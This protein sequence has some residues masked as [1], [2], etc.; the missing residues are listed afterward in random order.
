MSA[1]D[2]RANFLFRDLQG[3]THLLNNAI[4]GNNKNEVTTLLLQ[5]LEFC[6]TKTQIVDWQGDN[7]VMIKFVFNFANI[8]SKFRSREVCFAIFGSVWWMES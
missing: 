8:V 6:S 5:I 7:E 2:G 3:A 4:I 1:G